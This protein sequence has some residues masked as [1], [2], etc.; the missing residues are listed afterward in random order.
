M[1]VRDILLNPRKEPLDSTTEIIIHIGRRI[2]TIGKWD[3]NCI[4][5]YYGRE[6]KGTISG[7]S[8]HDGYKNAIDIYLD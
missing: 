2:V 7:R 8:E 3:D 5:N 6:T 4:I 1:T